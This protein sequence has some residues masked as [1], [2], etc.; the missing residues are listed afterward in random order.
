MNLRGL[1]NAK[2]I[3]VDEQQRYYL[4]HSWRDKMIHA[5]STDT[6]PK[7]NVIARLGFDLDPYLMVCQPFWVI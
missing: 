7:V 4:I 6:S 3:S 2:A 5:F 1:F